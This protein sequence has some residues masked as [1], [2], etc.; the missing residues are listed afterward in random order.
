ML[1]GLFLKCI[2]PEV[3]SV[4]VLDKLWQSANL[5]YQRGIYF[6]PATYSLVKHATSQ[7]IP[8][9]A[10]IAVVY[11]ACAM[12]I[13]NV[14]VLASGTQAFVQSIYSTGKAPSSGSVT[15]GPASLLKMTRSLGFG[16][17]GRTALQ[18]KS[19]ANRAKK[20]TSSGKEE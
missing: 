10:K 9:V 14:A 15:D 13:F 8:L 6:F 7:P 1:P 12:S 20:R 16:G 3:K 2:A 11:A 5:W 4:H 17:V 19:W 18:A